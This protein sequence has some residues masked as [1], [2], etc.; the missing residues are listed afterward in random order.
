MLFLMV[1]LLRELVLLAQVLPELVLL[2]QVLPELVLLVLEV[3]DNTLPNLNQLVHYNFHNYHPRK[4]NI[5]HI[6]NRKNLKMFQESDSHKFRHI[7]NCQ[8]NTHYMLLDP[9]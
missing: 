6:P 8:M 1:E 3:M 5:K 2:A 7:D 4:Y 9:K